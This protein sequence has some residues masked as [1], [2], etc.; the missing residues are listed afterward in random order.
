MRKMPE[1]M[2]PGS[3]HHSKRCGPMVVVKYEK[4]AE[5]TVK[6]KIT[7]TI[8][9]ANSSDI[10]AGKVKDKVHPS[11]EGVGFVGYGKHAPGGL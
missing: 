10:R 1:D 6:F 4:Q 7:G 11:V 2:K 8:L 5:V 9:T 3:I